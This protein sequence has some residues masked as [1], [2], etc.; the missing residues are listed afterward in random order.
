[1]AIKVSL[2]CPTTFRR[3]TLPAR[4]H[5]CKHIQV[6][7]N[8][9]LLSDSVLSLTLGQWKYPK[10][11]SKTL[12]FVF[13]SFSVLTWNPTW[14]SAVKE[15]VGDVRFVGKF[16]IIMQTWE[17]EGCFG[18]LNVLKLLLYLKCI[19][20]IATTRELILAFFSFIGTPFTEILMP[21]ICWTKLSIIY[22]LMNLFLFLS[23][24]SKGALLE[25]LEVDQFMWGILTASRWLL[26]AW[27]SNRTV[28]RTGT[29]VDDCARKSNN[30]I[31]QWHSGKLG[32]EVEF[33]PFQALTRRQMTFPSC[34]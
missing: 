33:S 11:Y 5:D 7:A 30:W 29:S 26:L 1:M 2:K 28:N 16:W 21:A 9:C 27:F 22:F 4:G 8:S 17:T 10:E 31:D 25:G 34:C 18:N 12:A 15:E 13:Y 24:C 6:N 23:F 20:K 32:T 14:H 3:I 19:W